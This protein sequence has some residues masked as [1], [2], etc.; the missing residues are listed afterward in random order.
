MLNLHKLDHIDV[1]EPVRCFYPLINEIPVISEEF[2]AE[3]WLDAFKESMF[4]FG[5]DAFCEK[6]QG[7]YTDTAGFQAQCKRHAAR[8]RMTDP[9]PAMREAI[10]AYLRAVIG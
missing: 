5:K 2:R 1:F 6:V 7:L 4:T 3:P 10:S 8:F 9:L